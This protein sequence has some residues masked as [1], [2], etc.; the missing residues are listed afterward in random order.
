MKKEIWINKK[1]IS[2][3]KWFDP[4]C[5]DLKKK[6]RK[7]LN[8]LRLT[9]EEKNQELYLERKETYKRL[10]A[11]HQNTIKNKK[12]DYKQSKRSKLSAETC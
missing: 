8:K 10:R 4:E 11:E 3:N 1:K 2:K 6:A 9:S 12:K 7:A 5:R